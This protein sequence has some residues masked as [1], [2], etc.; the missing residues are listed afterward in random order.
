MSDSNDGVGGVG[1]VGASSGA[2][3]AEQAAAASRGPDADRVA[4][5][6]VDAVR[7][8]NGVNTDALGGLVAG[9]NATNPA[10]GAEVQAAIE[11][12]LSAVDV[13]RLHSAIDAAA[14]T[15]PSLPQQVTT[16]AALAPD[17]TQVNPAYS[18]NAQGQMVDACGERV[19]SVGNP[20]RQHAALDKSL[21]D[22]TQHVDRITGGPISGLAYNA[23]YLSGA[24]PRTLDNVHALGKIADGFAKPLEDRAEQ[25]HVPLN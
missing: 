6:M 19:A 11:R 24:S 14:L 25:M 1:G 4:D 12:D 7:G 2:N 13:G 10:F 3:A 15:T 17:V 9:L 16:P 22:V 5:A 23:A 20:D 18:Y 21:A 8:P